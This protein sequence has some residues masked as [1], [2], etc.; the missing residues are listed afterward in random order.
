MFES[1]LIADVA[2]PDMETRVAI[3][4]KKA[5]LENLKMPREVVMYIAENNE[6]QP[7]HSV[8]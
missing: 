2:A 3:L 5:S 8:E 4:Q 6:G 7:D 1:G